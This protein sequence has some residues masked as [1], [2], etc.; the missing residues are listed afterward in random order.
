MLK[1][2][3]Y[4]S[5]RFSLGFEVLYDQKGSFSRQ[6][7]SDLHYNLHFA[8]IPVEATLHEWFVEDNQGRSFSRVNFCG[9]F[10]YNQLVAGTAKIGGI[11]VTDREFDEIRRVSIMF[12]L[13]VQAFFTRNI[14]VG[15]HWS[16]SL[17]NMKPPSTGILFVMHAWTGRLLYRF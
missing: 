5:K 15:V 16:R 4:F 17:Y 12:R 10:M 2:K 6:V 7:G 13:G 9:G 14:G 11:D 1:L 3:F 8:S